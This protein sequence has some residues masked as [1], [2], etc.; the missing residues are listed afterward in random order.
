MVTCKHLS[1]TGLCHFPRGL[2]WKSF[3]YFTLTYR[4]ELH[5]AIFFFLFCLVTIIDRQ[6]HHRKFFFNTI[7]AV[8][9]LLVPAHLTEF[10]LVCKCFLISFSYS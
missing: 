2:F 8:P 1:S 6:I 9:L 7:N 3:V 5:I 10:K 4:E